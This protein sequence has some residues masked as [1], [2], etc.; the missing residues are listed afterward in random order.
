[1]YFG[2]ELKLSFDFMEA[3][4]DLSLCDPRTNMSY[5]FLGMISSHISTK[6]IITK[7]SDNFVVHF[8]AVSS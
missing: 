8:T 7:H 1:M 3:V 5:L 6:Y 4:H 2:T